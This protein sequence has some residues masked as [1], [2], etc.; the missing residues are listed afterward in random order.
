MANKNKVRKLPMKMVQEDYDKY[1]ENLEIDFVENDQVYRITITPFFEPQRIDKAI[2]SFGKDVE[3]I[4]K[5][6]NIEFPDKLI[7]QLLLYHCVAEFSD[8]PISA[9]KDIKKRLAYFYQ[10]INTKYYKETTDQFLQQEVEKV[11]NRLMEIWS[12][13]EQLERVAAQTKERIKDLELQSP[14]L[15]ERIQ[16]I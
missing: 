10:V 12:A 14:E 1:K 11:W 2:E 8:F 6:D 5:K 4:S 3:D 15:R 13:N 9:S 7:P 16:G